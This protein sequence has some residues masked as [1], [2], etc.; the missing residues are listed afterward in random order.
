MDQRRDA[1]GENISTKLA[2]SVFQGVTPRTAGFQTV[3]Y[4]ALRDPT[5]TV[6]TVLMFIGAAPVSTGGG[7]KVTTVA[8][9]FMI[10]VAQ[11]RGEREVSAFGR[12]VSG[13]LV[14]EVLAL[15]SVAVLIVAGASMALMISDGLPMLPAFFEVTSA[16]GTVGLS[17]DVTPELSSFGKILIAL[18]MF[19][20]RVGTITLILALAERAKPRRYTYPEEDIAVG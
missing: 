3:D 4:T 7:I 17:L 18:V 14:S 5:L 10:L 9:I 19:A 15:S 8:L 13:T 12:R 1:R 11:G 2:E 16:F 6:Q 20:G